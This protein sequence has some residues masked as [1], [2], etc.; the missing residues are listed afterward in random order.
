MNI[1]DQNKLKKA[2]FSIVRKDDYPVPR[3]K[4]S[5][6]DNGAWMTL[7]KYSTKAE[8]DKAFADLLERD[9]FISD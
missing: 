8:R 3:I 2:G 6:G 1:N 9:K 7:G 5:V 4:I